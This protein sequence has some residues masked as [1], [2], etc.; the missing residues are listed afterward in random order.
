MKRS[1]VEHPKCQGSFAVAYGRRSLTRIKPQV[2]LLRTGKGTCSLGKGQKD[3]SAL[4]KEFVA[5]N[6]LVTT[7]WKFLLVAKT[8]SYTLSSLYYTMVYA[9]KKEIGPWRQMGC[10][11]EVKNNENYKTSP[12]V[13]VV[14]AYGRCSFTK[15]SKLKGFNWE[16]FGVLDGW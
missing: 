5:W 16:K 15:G 8:V 11:L 4:W 13:I 7:Q 9:A 10:L 3:S 1:I 6:F 2:T 14:V 12:E